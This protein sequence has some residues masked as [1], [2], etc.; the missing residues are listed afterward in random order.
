MFAAAFYLAGTGL[1]RVGRDLRRGAST[2]FTAALPFVFGMLTG[3]A[4]GA[5]SLSRSYVLPTYLTLALAQTYLSLA[6]PVP[7]PGD[8]VNTRWIKKFAMIA[9]GGAAF[10]KFSTQILGVLNG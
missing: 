6:Q 2:P 7:D 5:F 1:W 8:L 3:Y 10:V 9:L 4:A